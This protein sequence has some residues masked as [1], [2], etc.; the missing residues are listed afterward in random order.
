MGQGMSGS[1]HEFL[2]LFKTPLGTGTCRTAVQLD[3]TGTP[4]NRTDM[5][6]IYENG[7][8]A[9]KKLSSR[10]DIVSL[11]EPPH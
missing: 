10:R 1:L 7:F 5:P 6:G 9:E 4:E 11:R 3:I 8:V 2:K